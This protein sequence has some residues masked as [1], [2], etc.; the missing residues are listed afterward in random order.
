MVPTNFLPIWQRCF[1]N[2]ASLKMG[3]GRIPKL[4][5]FPLPPNHLLCF[6]LAVGPA[7]L[8]LARLQVDRALV[9][10]LRLCHALS[11]F[12]FMC[13]MMLLPCIISLCLSFQSWSSS[14]SHVQRHYWLLKF[15]IFCCIE[16]GL[17]AL[18]V[19]LLFFHSI[20]LDTTYLGLFYFST[21]GLF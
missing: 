1:P 21:F 9:A 10:P 15:V 16:L 4:S 5:L 7:S 11:L 3:L 20:L 8:A 6:S 19:S 13:F 12:F 2:K 17:L 14:L 18:L